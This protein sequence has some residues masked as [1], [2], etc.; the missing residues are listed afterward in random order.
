MATV[1]VATGLRGTMV[2]ATLAEAAVTVT[3]RGDLDALAIPEVAQ[4]IAEAVSG[5]RTRDVVL[6]VGDVTVM[7]AAGLEFIIRARRRLTKEGG[8]LTVSRP[9]AQIERLLAVC[10]IVDLDLST[11]GAPPGRAPA[12]RSLHALAALARDAEPREYAT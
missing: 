4:A 2:E 10:G 11:R 3:V 1:D 6:D 12:W 9:T 7:D 5:A 8:T